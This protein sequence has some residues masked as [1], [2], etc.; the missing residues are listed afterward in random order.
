[1][2]KYLWVVIKKALLNSLDD[3]T[4]VTIATTRPHAILY[5]EKLAEPGTYFI[6][7]W[8]VSKDHTR[9]SMLDSEM[10]DL[11]SKREGSKI[12]FGDKF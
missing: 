1:M 8:G 7:R 11:R 6:E 4:P 5:L 12:I 9:Y 3:D 10:V 2:N